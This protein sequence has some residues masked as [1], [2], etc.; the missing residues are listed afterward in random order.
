M[1]P[2]E[3]GRI[4]RGRHIQK[5]ALHIYKYFVGALTDGKTLSS[6]KLTIDMP[7]RIV[8]SL[9][10][11]R[12]HDQLR[13]F[14]L[15]PEAGGVAE[16]RTVTLGPNLG[17]E[18]AM[19]ANLGH[20]VLLV[21]IEHLRRSVEGGRHGRV[22]AKF[23][24]MTTHRCRLMGTVQARLLIL[25]SK[26]PYVFL[27]LLWEKGRKK[28]PPIYSAAIWRGAGG[29]LARSAVNCVWRV[30]ASCAAFSFT[31]P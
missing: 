1:A 23:K 13:K 30:L 28:T 17:I 8:G 29:G 11:Q 6:L 5:D 10:P 9:R 18:P 14:E 3:V 15:Q 2:P 24:G 19:F 25:H 7:E 22:F 12:E 31:G 16:P 20:E 21:L 26:P 4:S 27:L